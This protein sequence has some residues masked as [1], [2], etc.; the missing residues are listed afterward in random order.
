MK[1]KLAIFVMDGT[2]LDTLE[3]LKDSVNYSLNK[4]G[5]PQR[6]LSEVKSFVGNGIHK[7]IERAVPAG[8]SEE[9]IEDLIRRCS[10][11]LQRLCMQ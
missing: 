8:T 4:F 2:I 9:K 1:Y 10:T 11:R 5:Y 3:D 6:T 7:L